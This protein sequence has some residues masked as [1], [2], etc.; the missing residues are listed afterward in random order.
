MDSNY[1][2]NSKELYVH[3]RSKV[4]KNH[5]SWHYT[6]IHIIIYGQGGSSSTQKIPQVL[7]ADIPISTND[8]LSLLVEMK[9]QPSI[10]SSTN[11]L[12]L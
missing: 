7:T 9:E 1:L 12:T 6:F 2:P 3:I 11:L 4:K 8:T 10:I 5:T